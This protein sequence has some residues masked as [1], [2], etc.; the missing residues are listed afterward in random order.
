M[1]DMDELDEQT[2]VVVGLAEVFKEQ[3]DT[4]RRAGHLA[5]PALTLPA[6][7]EPTAGRCLS[8]GDQIARARWRYEVCRDA[9]DLVLE[10][11]DLDRVQDDPAVA[12]VHRERLT[13]VDSV[14]EERREPRR[15]PR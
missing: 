13:E 15:A 11:E 5:L 7:P 12:P 9:V 14:I 3:I 6:A 2:L 10:Q 4:W 1:T 8:C